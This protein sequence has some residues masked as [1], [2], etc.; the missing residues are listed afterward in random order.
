M[1]DGALAHALVARSKRDDALP[2][3]LLHGWPSTVS[4]FVHA[5]APL[6]APG[7]QGGEVR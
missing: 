7:E 1:V 4:E 2:L 3:V 6:T 5:I